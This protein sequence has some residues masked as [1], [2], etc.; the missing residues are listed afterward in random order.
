MNQPAPREKL[1]ATARFQPTS[2]IFQ[3]EDGLVF[4]YRM[5]GSPRAWQLGGE[6]ILRQLDSSERQWIVDA[7][8]TTLGNVPPGE[9]YMFIYAQR[10]IWQ[11]GVPE[12]D[13]SDRE[14]TERLAYVCTIPIEFLESLSRL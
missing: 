2:D 4:L 13:F 7:A 11:G 12:F 6:Q 5:L 3:P 14:L 10:V 8:K 1:M 9:K